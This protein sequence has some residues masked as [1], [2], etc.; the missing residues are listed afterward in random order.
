M[1]RFDHHSY[2]VYIYILRLNAY[3][4]RIFGLILVEINLFLHFY[5]F[6]H[7]LREMH[8]FFDFKCITSLESRGRI[9]GRNR[10][11]SLKSFPPCHSKSQSS[12]ITDF[13]PPYLSKSGLKLVC[14][15]N[16]VFGNLTSEDSQDYAQKSQRN[17]ASM[18]SASVKFSHCAHFQTVNSCGGPTTL[19]PC[20][21]YK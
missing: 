18:N 2:Y 6:H 13:T 5:T 14:N 10:D 8:N 1:I 12:L 3:I 11:K 4:L 16:I 15:V 19:D 21:L 20:T 17:F 7:V 9:L